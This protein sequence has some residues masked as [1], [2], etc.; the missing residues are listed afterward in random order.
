MT[1]ARAMAFVVSPRTRA[2]LLVALLGGMLAVAA[3]GGFPSPARVRGALSA[4]TLWAPVA[5]VLGIAVLA[6][7][8]FPRTGIAVLAGL[9]FGPWTAT[10]YIMLGTLLG[11]SVAFGVGRVLG[12]E[13]LDQLAAGRGRMARLDAWLDRRAFAAVVGAR[14]LPVVPF[15]LLNYGFGAT[16]VPLGTFVL[17]TAVGILPSTFL[18]TVVGASASDPTSPVFL[19]ATALTAVLAVVGVVIVGRMR[20]SGGTHESE[21][22]G[23]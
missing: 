15:G 13:Y 7:L 4:D 8:L 5:A 20:R 9:V 6:L 3:L 19:G 2:A 18:Y 12:R 16:R 1:L 23:R 17:G 22:S 21:S 10:G 14:L 11:G